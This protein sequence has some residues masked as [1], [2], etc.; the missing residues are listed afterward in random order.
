MWRL[1]SS[2]FH[3]FFIFEFPPTL[4]LNSLPMA[5]WYSSLIHTW[6]RF[7]H[8]FSYL[9]WFSVQNVVVQ[10]VSEDCDVPESRYEKVFLANTCKQLPISASSLEH[11]KSGLGDYV[12]KHGNNLSIKCNSCFTSWYVPYLKSAPCLSFRN[13]MFLFKNQ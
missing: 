8:S 7:W 13:I 4:L 2:P 1:I 5:P 3:Q 9:L 6:L 11:L 12:L 10:L